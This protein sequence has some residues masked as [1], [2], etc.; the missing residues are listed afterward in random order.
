MERI[1]VC[2]TFS[3]PP[4]VLCR[5]GLQPLKTLVMLKM[6]GTP[7]KVR[8]F[9]L[10]TAYSCPCAGTFGVPLDPAQGDFGRRAFPGPALS[11]KYRV[12]TSLRVPLNH[13]GS[14]P[15]AHG[16]LNRIIEKRN[17]HGQ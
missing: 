10:E 7:F 1:G 12:W 2:H 14:L 13:G 9:A 6:Q 5:K 15:Q 11:N 8:K 17:L 3:N 4:F 16:K